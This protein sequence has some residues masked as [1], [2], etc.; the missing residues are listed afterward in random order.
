MLLLL[1]LMLEQRR[2]WLT[3]K[4]NKV[5]PLQPQDLP[6]HHHQ[7]HLQLLQSQQQ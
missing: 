4:T 2:R 6:L 7:L 3:R 1:M 5:M